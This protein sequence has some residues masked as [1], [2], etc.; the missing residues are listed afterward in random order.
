MIR[1][2]ICHGF[3]FHTAAQTPK[4]SKLMFKVLGSFGLPPDLKYQEI[5]LELSGI[6]DPTEEEIDLVIVKLADAGAD[7]L[8]RLKLE[9]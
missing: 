6:D 4:V 3:T 8:T 7:Y 9:Q 1:H 2:A 5:F